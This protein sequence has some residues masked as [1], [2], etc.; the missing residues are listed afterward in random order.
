MLTSKHNDLSEIEKN[1]NNLDS[2]EI[3]I[4]SSYFNKKKS[5]EGIGIA[6]SSV[7]RLEKL[8]ML[9]VGIATNMLGAKKASLMILDG[10]IMRLRHSNHLSED[11][12]KRCKVKVGVGISGWVALKR[13][14]LLIRDIENDK[15]FMKRNNKRYSS[16]SFI[17]MPL[18]VNRKVIGVINVS[19]KNNN[20]LFDENDVGLLRV[21]S[22]YSA[23]AIRNAILVEKTKKLTIVEQLDGIYNDESNKF[24]PVTLQS[25]KMG[26]FHKSELYLENGINGK[27][28]YVLYWNGGGRLFV[29]EKREEFIRKNINR[30]FVPK[31]GKKQYLRF[32]ETNLERIVADDN[33]GQNEKHRLINDV[34]TSIISDLNAVP[35][36][37]CNIERSKQWVNVVMNLIY[38]SSNKGQSSIIDLVKARRSDEYFN[39]HSINVTMISLVFANHLGLNTDAL[40]KFGLGLFLKDIGMRR[41]DPL[42]VSKPSKLSKEEFAMIKKAP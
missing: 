29:N 4:K 40:N 15:R 36:D 2:E 42:V 19:D 5:V 3:E 32:M 9:I 28:V 12:M 10:N 22:R 11:I 30:L 24:L 13:L 23:I 20:E 26:P 14:P 41:V 38:K 17:S 31:N 39:G 16:K 33:T 37:T 7:F 8:F 35:D 18:I 6:L 25:L 21:I 27:K 1:K 34:A